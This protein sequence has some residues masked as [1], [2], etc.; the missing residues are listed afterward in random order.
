MVVS[1]AA[2]SKTYATQTAAERGD[3]TTKAGQNDMRLGGWVG[4]GGGV[5]PKMS[6]IRN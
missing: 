6:E 3:V 4:L 1:P 2:A 5:A